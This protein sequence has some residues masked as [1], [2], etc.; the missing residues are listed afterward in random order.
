MVRDAEA[1]R[2]VDCQSFESLGRQ[3]NGGMSPDSPQPALFA[4]QPFSWPE[5]LYR[6]E[7]VIELAAVAAL[8]VL[9]PLWLYRRRANRRRSDPARINDLRMESILEV[10]LV[11][12]AAAI[13]LGAAGGSLVA[14]PDPGLSMLVAGVAQAAG[15]AACLA[16]AR[17]HFAGGLREF[18]FGH[19]A[20][21]RRSWAGAVLTVLILAW[22]LCPM[23]LEITAVILEFFEPHHE[24][25]VHSTIR[26]L[27]DESQPAATIAFLWIGAAAVA[28]VAEE[29]FFRGLLQS[30][31][32][33]LTASR[34]LA[35]LGASLAFALG[36]LQQPHAVPALVGL[37]V[38]LGSVYERTGS[39]SGPILIHSLFNL[40]SLVWDALSTVP[41]SQ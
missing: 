7:L 25:P 35:I 34:W 4:Q 38:L 22:G 12:L 16:A 17:R 9:L 18:L 27:R 13:I 8:V 26:A 21:A 1:V 36:H 37:G 23:M 15:A 30:L 28:P 19:G 33:N 14:E 2:A 3:E 10:V 31:L 5:V 29:L 11:Y 32:L 6:V 39:L 24:F 41:G 40:K 20:V